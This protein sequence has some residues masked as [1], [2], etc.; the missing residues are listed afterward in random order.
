MVEFFGKRFSK[1]NLHFLIDT[2]RWTDIKQFLTKGHFSA[3]FT[4]LKLVSFLSLEPLTISFSDNDQF[5]KGVLL[6]Q[7]KKQ[8]LIENLCLFLEFQM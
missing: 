7:V 2:F 6:I 3:K 5:S 8:D 4:R 1:E